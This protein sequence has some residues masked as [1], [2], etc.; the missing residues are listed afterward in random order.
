MFDSSWLSSFPEI[1]R[2]T[3]RN[4][5]K[6][7]DGA[8]KDFSREYGDLIESLFDP[9]L[10]FLVWFEKLL[11]AT[12]WFIVL[13]VITALIYLASRSIKL[14]IGGVIA[15]IFIGYLGMWE[16]TMRTLSIITVCT[17]LA[18]VVGIPIGIAMARSNRVQSVVTP[19]LDIMQTMPAF[20][21]LIPVV[22]L[23]GIG[24]IPGLI[25]VVIY[26]IPPVIRLT[27]LGIRLVDKEV[28]EAA[29]AFGASRSQ[30]LFG[31]QLPLAMPTIMAGINQTVMMALS[32]VVIASMIGVKGLGQP[33]LK[34]IT[35]QYFTL[36]LLNGL[37][38]V[39]LAILIDRST[40]AY[41]KR[42][43]AHLGDLRHD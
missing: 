36:G 12:P 37:A 32:M 3:M 40:Q 16:D 9:L 6:S 43:Q 1:D 15:L 35:N 39:V 23:L 38:I 5:R 29:T 24:K 42:T 7:L 31:V 11:L 34:S 13:A 21:Y 25:A 10:S 8:Y 28:M 41:A 30:R 19:I 22:M 18:I 26:A 27:N 20:V 17:L 2:S 33:V 14:T 4:I